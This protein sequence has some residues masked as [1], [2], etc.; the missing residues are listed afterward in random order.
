M[1]EAVAALIAFF[2]AAAAFC[3]WQSKLAEI[4]TKL[5][6]KNELERLD[7]EDED[8][9]QEIITLRGRSDSSSQLR[10]TWLRERAVRR[11]AYRE[12][13][14]TQFL[15]PEKGTTDSNPRGDL[16]TPEK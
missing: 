15:V 9:E 10:A 6:L 2:K 1:R 7:K 11:T 8:G 4:Q 3:E 12:A 5:L 16:P 13:L 14:P